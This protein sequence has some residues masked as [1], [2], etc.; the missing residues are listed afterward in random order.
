MQHF[1][2]TVHINSP[3]KALEHAKYKATNSRVDTVQGAEEPG[4]APQGPAAF[5]W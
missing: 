4:A 1:L 2:E 5:P 3:V